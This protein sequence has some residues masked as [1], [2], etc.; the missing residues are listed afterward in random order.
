MKSG[1]L[2]GYS[3][4]LLEP[5]RA[6]IASLL[7]RAG[8]QTG[9]VG[10]WHLGMRM[11]LLEEDANTR[12]WQGDPGIDFAGV[13][14]DSPVH[15]GF[16]YYFGVS[17]SL[18]MAPY[19][20]IRNDRFTAQPTLQQPA[21]G[22]PHFVRQ[23]PRAADFV[24][25]QVLDRPVEEASGF[26]G[27]QATRSAP[28]FLY[29][30][31][32]AP[33]KPTQPHPRFRGT[34]GLGEYGDFIAQ[35]DDAVGQI[36]AAIESTGQSEST[37][38]VFTSD[39]GSYMHRFDD[40]S[41]RDHT[42]DETIQGYR[43]DS[44]T[45]NG[46]WRGTKADIYEGGHHVPFLVRWPGRLPANRVANSTI[47]QV[48]LFA[49]CAEVAGQ[50]LRDDEAEDSFSFLDVALGKDARRPAAVIHQSVSGMLALRQDQW[51]LIAG[52]GSGGRQQPRGKPWEQPWQLYDLQQD[53]AETRDLAAQR[54]AIVSQLG[55]LLERYRQ[56]GSRSLVGAAAGK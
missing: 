54:P 21:V 56:S 20:Y 4:P 43:A 22:F 52:N 19:V 9:A 24:I 45:A 14:S 6:T 35:V 39:N 18:D 11:P 28:W 36:L 12:Q 26:I 23:G 7:K 49:T 48:D 47:C 51:K 34:T 8:Y 16:D 27:R 46:P 13:I 3:P 17:A 10:K 37:L 40:A 42:D 33:H 44:H 1:V 15:H 30:P 38:V 2:G 50:S 5:E 31:F 41:R 53:P 25:D 55:D 32:T 29:V